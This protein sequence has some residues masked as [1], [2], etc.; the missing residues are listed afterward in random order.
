VPGVPASAAQ[1]DSTRRR[2]VPRQPPTTLIRGSQG[3]GARS[4]PPGPGQRA[5]RDG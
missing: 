4:L 5:E 2:S 3:R 1:I